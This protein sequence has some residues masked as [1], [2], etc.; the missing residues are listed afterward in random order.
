MGLLGSKVYFSSYGE[1]KTAE[2]SRKFAKE[3]HQL[4]SQVIDKLK[5]S[6]KRSDSALKMLLA[7]EK[8]HP[9]AFTA[10]QAN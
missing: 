6:Y 4:L 8:A 10:K 7:H 5:Q 3:G 1:G 2:A 9:E